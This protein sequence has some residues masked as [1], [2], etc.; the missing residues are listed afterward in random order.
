MDHQYLKIAEEARTGGRSTVGQSQGEPEANTGQS[1]QGGVVLVVGDW[2]LDEHWVIGTHRSATSSRTGQA[3]YRALHVPT[4]TVQSLCGAGR[5]ASILHQVENGGPKFCEVIGIGIWHDEDTDAL[6]KMLDPRTGMGRTPH[7]VTRTSDPVECQRL[8]NLLA[9]LNSRRAGQA[10][11]CGTTRIIRIYQH[12]AS[13]FDLLQRIDWEVQVPSGEEFGIGDSAPTES[14]GKSVWI[15]SGAIL[16]GSP[17]EAFLSRHV[18]KIRAVVIKDMQKGVISKALIQWLAAKLQRI[19]WY[20]S[21]KVWEPDW[22]EQVE[23]AGTDV[24]LLIIPQIAAQAAVRTGKMGRWITRSGEASDRALEKIEQLGERFKNATIVALPDGLR[25]LARDRL[26]EGGDASRIG[27]VQTDVGPRLLTVGVPMASVLFPALVARMLESKEIDL[28]SL[29]KSSLWFTHKW[30]FLE[31]KRVEDP[32]RWQPSQDQ[33]LDLGARKGDNASPSSNSFDGN[34]RAF[35]WSLARKAWTEAFSEIGIVKVADPLATIPELLAGG[36]RTEKRL[37]I[38]RAMTEVNG[39]VC[40]VRSR[41]EKLQR[42]VRE[43]SSFSARRRRDHKSCLLIASPGS[44]KTFLVRRLAESLNLRFLGFNVTQMISKSDLLDCFDTIVTSQAQNPAEPLLVFIDEVNSWLDRQYVYDAFLAPLEEGVYVRAGKTFHIDPCVWVFAGTEPPVS[45]RRGRRN[46]ADK[47]SD[48]VSRLSIEP[49][50]LKLNFRVRPQEEAEARVERV[51]LGV[52]MLRSE[53]PDVRKVSEKVLKAFH[54]L[55][56]DLEARETKH[57]VKSFTDIQYGE[58][59]VRNINQ[60]RF[61]ELCK[62]ADELFI[63][64]WEKLPERHTDMIEIVS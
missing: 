20:I 28:E 63:E 8:F 13:G 35:T 2:F 3:H 29:L 41:R 32:E 30:M 11:S 7:Q 19:P 33:I 12:T 49:L 21:T 57:F 10:I 64:D 23:Q 14:G 54:A 36:G 39:Y 24:R 60:P 16:D 52:S 15:R 27:M 40:C 5:T 47:A 4:S 25:V 31:A 50:D 45:R 58:V 53:F 51:Y 9:V 44:G 17:L 42:L 56:A 18:S 48:F 26:R 62:A 1:S 37:E 55:P 61:R 38:W 59:R 6:T 34:W 46:K 22:L 43:L